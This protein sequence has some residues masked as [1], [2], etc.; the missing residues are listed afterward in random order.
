ML[1]EAEPRAPCQPQQSARLVG[2]EIPGVEHRAGLEQGSGQL[3]HQAARQQEGHRLPPGA[4]QR[5][6]PQP[7]Q[8]V[9]PR[10]DGGPG[11]DVVGVAGQKPAN[12]PAG[13]GDQDKLID[14]V[15]QKRR[16]A[17]RQAIPL[18]TYYTNPSRR[19]ANTTPSIT[20]STVMPK[21]IW[22]FIFSVGR[23]RE[24][25]GEYRRSC[26]TSSPHSAG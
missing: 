6:L 18:Y 14:Q 2:G 10:H 26:S 21:V 12:R 20:A 9:K 8:Q 19:R 3:P 22:I 24:S 16:P 7:Q 4:D 25:T 17:D 11:K 13:G 5:Q 1:R 23:D 15:E